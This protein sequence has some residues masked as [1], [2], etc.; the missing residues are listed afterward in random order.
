MSSVCVRLGPSSCEHRL[1]PS[2]RPHEIHLG[3]PW[4]VAVADRD[5]DHFMD[6]VVAFGGDWNPQWIVGYSGDTS[7]CNGLK[8]GAAWAS[9]DVGYNSRVRFADID[10]AAGVEVLGSTYYGRRR[11]ANSGTDGS[12]IRYYRPPVRPKVAS[13]LN[14]KHDVMRPT[15]L[16][17]CAEVSDFQVADVDGDGDLD[18]LAALP[19]VDFHCPPDDAVKT[20]YILHKIG[21]LSLNKSKL[22]SLKDAGMLWPDVTSSIFAGAV[23]PL[24]P[25][26]ESSEIPPLF[27]YS[28]LQPRAAVPTQSAVMPVDADQ[29]AGLNAAPQPTK[30]AEGLD[31]AP[32]AV[33]EPTLP[34]KTKLSK[35]VALYRNEGG[36]G[37]PRF[38]TPAWFGRLAGVPTRVEIFDID[39]DGH[40]DFIV[41]VAGDRTYAIL[42]GGD[43]P[44]LPSGSTIGPKAGGADL[45]TFG[46]SEPRMT[47]DLVVALLPR[48]AVPPELAG[49]PIADRGSVTRTDQPG[50][51]AEKDLHVALLESKMCH[52]G[53]CTDP[54]GQIVL[55]MV[56][57][58]SRTLWER[59]LSEGPPLALALVDRSLDDGATPTRLFSPVLLVGSGLARPDLQT[60]ALDIAALPLRGTGS[61]PQHRLLGEPLMGL[62]F[63]VMGDFEHDAPTWTFEGTLRGEAVTLPGV[64][65]LRVDAVYVGGLEIPRCAGAERPCFTIAESTTT[66]VVSR[67][68]PPDQTIR[69]AYRSSKF[70]DVVTA[71]ARLGK[72]HVIAWDARRDLKAPSP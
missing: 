12:G 48:S 33:A 61:P 18:I 26:G 11:L 1:K 22:S 68:T 59:P 49:P 55:H 53:S 36:R 52:P 38:T 17:G 27:W 58:G 31:G 16:I 32:P 20:E 23:D 10:E 14:A 30:Y 65:P 45:L 29:T 28:P 50:A 19:S 7:D 47:S 34:A 8:R 56:G 25:A 42:G 51:E 71:D 64:A 5:D 9:E 41:A 72:S 70:Q 60:E 35:L 24:K 3:I 69:V 6:L 21:L 66:L 15:M 43:G 62:D 67:D 46:D 37:N 44:R 2:K 39:R 54:A 4:R 57:G 40:L 63:E 13:C